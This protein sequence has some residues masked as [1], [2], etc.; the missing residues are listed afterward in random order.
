MVESN[1]NPQAL[2]SA[3]AVGLMQVMPLIWEGVFPQCGEVVWEW[4]TNICYGIHVLDHYLR[5]AKGD[6]RLALNL[7][8]GGASWYG[9][10]ESPYTKRVE[11]AL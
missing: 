1:G 10:G 9:T 11:E 8:W 7:Y 3:G 2:S 4:R 5:E 6:V